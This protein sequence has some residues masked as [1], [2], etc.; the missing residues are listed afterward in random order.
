MFNAHV[1]LTERTY[2]NSVYCDLTASSSY[3]YNDCGIVAVVVEPGPTVGVDCTE[4][5]SPGNGECI[6]N[7][8]SAIPGTNSP[9]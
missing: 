2:C 9:S 3:L 8:R 4:G 6:G 5:R 7:A 1:D